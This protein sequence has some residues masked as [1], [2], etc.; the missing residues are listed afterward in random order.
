LRG[1]AGRWPKSA[2]KGT[3]EIFYVSKQLLY[4]LQILELFVKRLPLDFFSPSIVTSKNM[5]HKIKKRQCAGDVYYGITRRVS[6][7]AD[8][9]CL[10]TS[11]R[12]HWSNE[13]SCCY[14]LNS[15]FKKLLVG[16]VPDMFDFNSEL[17]LH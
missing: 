2:T 1:L 4:N 3:S 16:F 5:S 6:E 11:H 13:N 8:A 9:K 7:Q 14:I 15:K 17:A 12:R 10:L